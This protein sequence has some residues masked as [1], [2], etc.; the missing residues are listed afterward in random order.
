MTGFPTPRLAALLAA[1]DEARQSV[2]TAWGAIVAQADIAPT[3]EA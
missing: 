1:L 2:R 3:G